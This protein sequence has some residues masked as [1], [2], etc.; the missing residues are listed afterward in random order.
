MLQLFPFLGW[1]AVGTS[2]TLLV[3]LFAG[4]D[5][6][7]RSGALVLAC[8]LAAAYGQFFGSSAVIAAGG[9]VLQTLLAIGLI[10][11]WRLTG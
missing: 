7:P 9:L 11:R 1:L 10:V 5:L 4:G 6:R 8:L 2:V 3:M